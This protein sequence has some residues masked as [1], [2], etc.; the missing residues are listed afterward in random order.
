MSLV[1]VKRDL[2]DRLVKLIFIDKLGD[3]AKTAYFGTDLPVQLGYFERLLAKNKEGKGYFVGDN[4][5]IADAKV[6][7]VLDGHTSMDSTVLDKY[8]LLKAFYSRV[9]ARDNINSYLTSTRRPAR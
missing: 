6:W 2:S 8:P 9:A 3:E 4:F 5:T 1:I 7:S